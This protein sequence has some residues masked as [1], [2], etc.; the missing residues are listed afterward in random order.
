MGRRS[1][2]EMSLWLGEC[3]G[4]WSLWGRVS[5]WTPRWTEGS[6]AAKELER[7]PIEC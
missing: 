6:E 5:E 3:G 4:V 7:K 1:G 2:W